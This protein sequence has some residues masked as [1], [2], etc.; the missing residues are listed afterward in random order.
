MSVSPAQKRA[1]P[2]PVPGP[3]TVTATSGLDSANTPAA[4][5]E[6]GAEIGTGLVGSI[7]I[8]AG[9]L[10]TKPGVVLV[11]AGARPQ[12]GLLACSDEAHASIDFNH[13]PHSA[14][15]DCSQTRTVGPNMLNLVVWFDNEWGFASRMVDVTRRWLAAA[16]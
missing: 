3:S 6:R 12:R 8:G 15:I 7:T 5:A 2:S 16:G 9:Q 1:K 4:A 10:C 14:I 13:D 11:P